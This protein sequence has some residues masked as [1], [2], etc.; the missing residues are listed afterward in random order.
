MTPLFKKLNYK[1]QEEI[2]IINA[3]PEFDAE[4]LAMK[5]FANIN[6]NIETCSGIDFILTFV[7]TQDEV[8][9]SFSKLLTGLKGDC[10]LWFAYPK[11]TSKKYKSEINRDK[12][13]ETLQ[14]NG[15]EGVRSV[16]IDEDWSAVRFRRIVFIKSL[17]RKK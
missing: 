8:E 16:A 6:T 4:M 17:T 12:G 7:R 14:K 13:W 3:P 2:C 11:G 5:A 10:I 9:I 1:G 15:F